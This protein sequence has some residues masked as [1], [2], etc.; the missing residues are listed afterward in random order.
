MLRWHRKPSNTLQVKQ[1][2]SITLKYFH[3]Y[4]KLLQRQSRGMQ[5]EA[6]Q[7]NIMDHN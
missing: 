3:T 6:R 4:H 5:I 7:D 2:P 1:S